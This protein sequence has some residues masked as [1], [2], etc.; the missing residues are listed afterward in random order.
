MQEANNY[1]RHLDKI[2]VR[3]RVGNKS[4]R[5]PGVWLLSETCGNLIVWDLSRSLSQVKNKLPHLVPLTLKKTDT[6]RMNFE[7]K[8]YFITSI[9][10]LKAC[11]FL[12]GARKTGLCNRCW[13]VIKL[14][15]HWNPENSL[16]LEDCEIKY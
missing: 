13:A 5:N 1:S 14:L 10:N 4:H 12:I 3:R 15:Y 2:H 6:M 8:I 9:G 16:V 11:Q 7:N